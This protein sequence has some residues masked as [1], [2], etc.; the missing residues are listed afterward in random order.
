MFG[1]SKFSGSILVKDH[2]NATISVNGNQIGTGSAV[3]LFPRNRP[4][5][6]ELEQ[7]GCETKTVTF[8]NTF[9]TGNF[10][11]SLF[12]WGLVGIAIDLG[13]GASYKPDHIS[14]PSIERMSDKNYLFQVDYKGCPN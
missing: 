11:L 10:I 8:N 6:V 5:A 7:E 9:R 2:P 14:N 3:G 12:M 4:L 1:G 13:T